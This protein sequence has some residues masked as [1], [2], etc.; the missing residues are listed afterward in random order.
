MS[1]NT[2]RTAADR[3]KKIQINMVGGINP[4]RR[5]DGIWVH[6]KEVKIMEEYLLQVSDAILS[7]H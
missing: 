2:P 7:T 1:K 3:F 6:S 4:P 5:L